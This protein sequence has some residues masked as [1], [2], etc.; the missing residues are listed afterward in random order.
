M[1]HTRNTI[2]RPWRPGLQLGAAP[3][4]KGICV[5]MESDKPYQG[6]LQ[7]DVPRHRLYMGF[8]QDWPRMNAVP[9]WFVVEPDEA[10]TYTLTD[11]DSRQTKTLSGKSMHEGV[12]VR[13]DPGKP[14]RLVIQPVGDEKGT[15]R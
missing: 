8:E 14:L 15:R 1:L 4:G 10:H 3:C 11:V 13:L 12:P 6:R 5:Y 9:E 7:F 2:A